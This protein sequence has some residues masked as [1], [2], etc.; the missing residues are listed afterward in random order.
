MSRWQEVIKSITHV[1]C[2]D[3]VDPTSQEVA[4]TFAKA[5]TAAG[6]KSRIEFKAGKYSLIISDGDGEIVLDLT[7]K[8]NVLPLKG[9]AQ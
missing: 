2:A 7:R 5:F 4:E 9:S 3:G 6:Y 8:G 1:Q